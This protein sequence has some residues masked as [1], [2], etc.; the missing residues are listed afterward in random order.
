MFNCTEQVCHNSEMGW[1]VGLTECVCTHGWSQILS[2][3]GLVV[4]AFA[5]S[6]AS[7]Q[8][9]AHVR[10]LSVEDNVSKCLD[11]LVQQ[12]CLMSAALAL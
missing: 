9:I 6:M 12:M 5:L 3:A 2:H 4:L 7:Q 11:R 1:R 8:C 10:M